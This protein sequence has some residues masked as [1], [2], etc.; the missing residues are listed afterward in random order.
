MKKFNILCAFMGVAIALCSCNKED[1]VIK[2]TANKAI[3]ETNYRIVDIDQAKSMAEKLV[4]MMGE[5][6]AIMGDDAGAT[7]FK[8]SSVEPYSTNGITTMYF[9]NFG[10]NNG[11]MVLSADKE[12]S[13]SMIAFNPKGHLSVSGLEK[14]TGV[15][16]QFLKLGK[17]IAEELNSGVDKSNPKYE[18]WDAMGKNANEDIEIG[19]RRIEETDISAPGIRARHKGSYGLEEITPYYMVKDYVWGPGEGYNADAKV[20]DALLGPAVNIGL[21]CISNRFPKK[22]PYH[23]MFKDVTTMWTNSVSKM[24]RDIA[25]Q[26]PN[27]K[28]NKENYSKASY[29]D[30]L[31]CLI[32]LGYKDAKLGEYDL[33]LYHKNVKK[34]HPVLLAGRDERGTHVWIADGYYEGKAEFFSRSRHTARIIHR[35]YEYVDMIFINWGL[36]GES[37][38]WFSHDRIPYF[39]QDRKIFYDLDP[40]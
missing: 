27:F 5:S 13:S 23:E 33:H 20:K 21:L 25:D 3:T 14:E 16:Q 36:N 35:W 10:N 8:I 19:I 12:A 7:R 34:K 32:S 28:W 15:N 30:I 17:T 4:Q 37:N 38:Q 22:Y 29:E 26:I 11:Y 24:L 6:K 40:S 9:I 18:L 39:K 2:S 1:N 31:A